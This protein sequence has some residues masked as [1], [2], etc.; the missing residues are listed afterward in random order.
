MKIRY[1]YVGALMLALLIYAVWPQPA[2][3]AEATIGE[4]APR[5]ELTSLD[6]LTYA[7][8]PSSD[9]KLLV[10][11]FWATWC[12][13]C[14]KEARELQAFYEKH[15][16]KVELVAVNLT[17]KD[18]EA[19]VRTFATK[20]DLRLPVLLDEKSKAADAYHIAGLPTTYWIDSS[21]IVAGRKVGPVDRLFLEGLLPEE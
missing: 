10:V 19:D 1:L 3:E 8:R 18:K 15:R 2:E 13:P 7:L 9:D 4:S 21:G 14:K 12:E 5:I 20:Y 16:D 6:G 11:N 17:S